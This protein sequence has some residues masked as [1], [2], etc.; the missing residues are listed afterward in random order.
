MGAAC[1]PHSFVVGLGQLRFGIKTEIPV[2]VYV[3]IVVI[4][5]YGDVQPLLKHI[6][7]YWRDLRKKW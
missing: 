7:M 4:Q 6:P 5:L 1:R 2:M 3:T